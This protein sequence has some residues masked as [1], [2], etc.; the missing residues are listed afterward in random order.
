MPKVV[1]KCK[2]VIQKE[3]LKP[4]STEGG[5]EGKIKLIASNTLIE[6]NILS[7]SDAERIG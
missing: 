7:L 3:K 1:G 6:S 2:V 4:S 5:E